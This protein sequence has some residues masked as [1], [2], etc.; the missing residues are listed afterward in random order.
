MTA[1][2][3]LTRCF[4]VFLALKTTRFQV[5]V[6]NEKGKLPSSVS[7]KIKQLNKD[8][9]PEYVRDVNIDV[10]IENESLE[11]QSSSGDEGSHDEDSEESDSDDSHV[12]NKVDYL[13]DV[14]NHDSDCDDESSLD[15]SISGSRNNDESDDDVRILDLFQDME[16]E[17]ES[18]ES[19]YDPH[20]DFETI[21]PIVF[22]DDVYNDWT[23]LYESTLLF[24][25]WLTWMICRALLSGMDH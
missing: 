4:L 9:V 10:T 14:D 21:E 5:F 6:R 1:K 16:S 20:L 2:M 8:K 22:T 24:Y 17:D 12:A 19:L 25:R 23:A 13:A 3:R 15:S 11:N 18:D 7:R